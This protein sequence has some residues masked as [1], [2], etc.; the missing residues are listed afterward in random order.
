M[1][2]EHDLKIMKKVHSEMAE[3]CYEL[4]IINLC[5]P[6]VDKYLHI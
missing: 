4:Q 3:C 2:S 5:I 6:V 1:G